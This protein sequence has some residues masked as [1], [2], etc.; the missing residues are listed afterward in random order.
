MKQI[1]L[2]KI[3]REVSEK[4]QKLIRSAKITSILILV[5]YCLFAA[6]T[7]SFWLVSRKESEQMARKVQAQK[8]R[9]N[10]LEQIEFL[11]TFLKQRLSSL[12][13]VLTQ[14]RVDYKTSLDTLQDFIPDGIVL[15]QVSLDQA[16]HLSFGGQAANALALANLLEEL[17]GPASDDF[18]TN[19]RLASTSRQEN[20]GYTFSLTIDVKI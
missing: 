11:Y 20:G 6:G 15:D 12:V 18:A 9:I 14:E 16:G 7:F 5:F 3:Q 2:F 10:D 8:E 19:V 4:R 13:P 1:N 17:A